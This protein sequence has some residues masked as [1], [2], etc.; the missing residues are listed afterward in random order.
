MRNE[1]NYLAKW[2]LA[3]KEH[4]P[5]TPRERAEIAVD[6]ANYLA[7]GGVITEIPFGMGEGFDK[8]AAP[9]HGNGNPN[10]VIRPERDARR[11]VPREEDAA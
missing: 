11:D 3:D 7:A 5:P 10:I 8:V 6:M 4:Q 1:F 9:R 2:G